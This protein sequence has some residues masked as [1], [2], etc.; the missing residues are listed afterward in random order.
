MAIPT[1]VRWY[2][3]VVLICTS[4]IISDVEH[5]FMCLLA[6]CIS[7]LEKCLFRSVAHFSISCLYIPKIKPL[8]VASFETIFSYSISCLFVFF[9]VSFA[10]KKL[11]SLIRS[12]WFIFYHMIQQSHS[13]VYI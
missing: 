10:R 12:H 6:I 2:L 9:F 5:F 1:G 4:V 13:W 7:S 8:P 3:I 11:V